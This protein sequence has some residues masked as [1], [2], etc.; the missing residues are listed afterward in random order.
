MLLHPWQY[1]TVPLAERWR[2]YWAYYNSQLKLDALGTFSPVQL[3][4][5][6]F[7]AL[8]IRSS[9]AVS[10]LQKY[11]RITFIRKNSVLR[12]L[13]KKITFS[14]SVSSPLIRSYRIEF[15]FSISVART[16][17]W[18]S[19]HFCSRN[20]PACRDTRSGNGVYGTAGTD[21]VFTEPVTETAT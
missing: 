6:C 4:H 8:R 9:V 13:R 18:S 14:V 7:P 19:T 16:Y 3:C 2:A 10:P 1:D 20:S 12:S 17:A 11:V 15:Y 5:A 21:T